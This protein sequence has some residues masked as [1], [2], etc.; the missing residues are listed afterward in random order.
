MDCFIIIVL[1]C[2]R[3]GFNLLNRFVKMSCWIVCFEGTRCR[4]NE[5]TN[6][7]LESAEGETSEPRIRFWRL[8]GQPNVPKNVMPMPLASAFFPNLQIPTQMYFERRPSSEESVQISTKC[9]TLDCSELRYTLL[10]SAKLRVATTLLTYARPNSLHG[11]LGILAP[12]TPQLNFK[13]PTTNDFFLSIDQIRARQAHWSR[14]LRLG[15]SH[16]DRWPEIIN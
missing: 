15:I 1:Y 14:S 9:V 2:V 13:P 7:G 11:S 4:N 3:A 10:Q 5:P 16:L 12:I 8:Y 6:F